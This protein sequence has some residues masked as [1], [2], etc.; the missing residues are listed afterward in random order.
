[1][2][3]LIR[4]FAGLFIPIVCAAAVPAQ[5]NRGGI[6]GTVFDATGAV[7]PGATVTVTNV[8]TNQT[9]KLTTSAEGVFT[10]TSLEPVV[11]SV[12]IEASGFKKAVVNNVKVDTATTVNVNVTLQPGGVETVIDV[13]ADTPLLNTISGTPGQTITERQISEM[14]LNNRSV[15]DLV[16]TVG[17]VSGVAGTEDPELGQDIPA[18]G[19]NVNINGG[20]AGSTA[21]LADGANNTG[22]GLGRAIVTFSPDTVQE[23]TVQTSNFSAEFG[24]TG[25]GVVNLTTKSGTNQY[26]GLAYWYHRN[27]ALNAAPFTTNATN[28]PVSSR[29]QSQFGLIYGGPIVLPKKVFGPVGYD[30]HDKSFFFVALEPRY[31]YDGVQGTLLMPTPAMLGGDFSNVVAVNGGYA[32]RA[33]AERFGLQTQ[34]RDATLYNQWVLEGNQFRQATLPAG[35]TYPVFTN[36]VIPQNM[37]DQTSLSLLKYLPKAGEYFLDNGNLRNYVQPTFVKD[38][39]QRLTVRLDHQISNKNR[40]YGRYTQ[41]PVRGDR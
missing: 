10:A 15:L 9:V 25:G 30:G 26:N 5:T 21:I 34:I 28:R 4:L 12:T 19:F 24:Q 37:L 22:V 39:E 29:R 6:S 16:L 7:V 20:R 36:N 33:V 2:K 17:N 14:P 18:P 40:I 35:G 8:G 38:F 41:V 3:T 27:P 31:Y 13:T 1:M 23:F 11:Y 32:P